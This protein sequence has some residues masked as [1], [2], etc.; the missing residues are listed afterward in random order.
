LDDPTAR[1]T[2]RFEPLIVGE[3]ENE[4]GPALRFGGMGSRQPGRATSNETK[5]PEGKD[6]DAKSSGVASGPAVVSIP[7]DGLVF[8][9]EWRKTVHEPRPLAPLSF[10]AAQSAL[11][12]EGKARKLSWVGLLLGQRS[13]P[14]RT[15]RR[16]RPLGHPRQNRA[17][18]SPGFLLQYCSGKELPRRFPAIWG[19]R[20]GCPVP[21]CSPAK[22]RPRPRLS[23][24]Q[25]SRSGIRSGLGLE[26][27]DFA[28]DTRFPIGSCHDWGQ[29]AD[30]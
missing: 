12:T 8:D 25:R 6:V 17:P 13:S 27:S 23:R 26:A 9:P 20:R 16:A 1:A 22:P 7:G 18:F 28:I 21:A 30:S 24:H 2:Q 11:E 5:E 4:I 3:D 29:E 15:R 14:P 19:N 10:T